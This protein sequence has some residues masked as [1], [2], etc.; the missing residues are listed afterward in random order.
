MRS[1]SAGSAARFR[2]VLMLAGRRALMRATCLSLIGL[3]SAAAQADSLQQRQD[4]LRAMTP[5]QRVRLSQA[6]AAWDAL[7]RDQREE[8]RARYQAWLQLDQAERV[9]LRVMAA[10]VGAYPADRRH[11][12]RLQFDALDDVQRHG[13]RLGPVLGQE[14][15]QLHPLL[16]Y[17][18]QAQRLPLL[19]R[20][21]AMSA[22]QRTDLALLAQRT[23]PQDR[24]AL[25]SELLATPAGAVSGWLAQKLGQ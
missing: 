23:P 19:A 25:R 9:R 22:Q 15:A 14:Y 20:L 18:P 12:L 2:R 8:R 4:A 3:A 1:S 24:Q 16:A 6:L 5:E 7:P 17:V 13:W 10:Q 21:R 11:A